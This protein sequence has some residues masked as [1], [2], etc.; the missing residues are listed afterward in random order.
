M[1]RLQT[2][3]GICVVMLLG[4]CATTPDTFVAGRADNDLLRFSASEYAAT[5]SPQL[6]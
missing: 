1:T 6:R 2:T 3:L 5:P 4:A